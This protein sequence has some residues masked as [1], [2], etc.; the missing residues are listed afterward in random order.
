MAKSVW[1][2]HFTPFVCSLSLLWLV[3]CG[4]FF[5]H[6]SSQLGMSSSQLTHIF[7]RS[8]YTTNQCYLCWWSFLCDITTAPRTRP[9]LC[10]VPWLESSPLRGGMVGKGT[11]SWQH[12]LVNVGMIWYVISPRSSKFIH[13]LL[14]STSS[15]IFCWSQQF[16]FVYIYTSNIVY[17]DMHSHIPRAGS[18]RVP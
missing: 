1:F 4:T 6:F 16:Y 17:I 12:W 9:V 11:I 8:R 2:F 3:V 18:E 15:S 13:I 5:I 7:Q 14:I 10:V